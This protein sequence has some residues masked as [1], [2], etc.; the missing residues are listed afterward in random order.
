MR[1]R[2]PVGHPDQQLDDRPPAPRPPRPLAQRPAVHV[3]RDQVLPLL[4][5]PR[6]VHRHDVRVVERG[7]QLRFAL[8]APPRF[9][10]RQRLRQHLDRRRTVELR[11]RRSVHHP[12]PAGAERPVDAVAADQR[13]GL[14]QC[15][16]RRLVPGELGL[17]LPREQRFD[18]LPQ[19]VIVPRLPR[20]ERRPLADRLLQR[21]LV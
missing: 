15:A 4:I 19:S 7:G 12:H 3:L 5:L 17:L 9:R 18:L 10:I 21:R 6:V 16:G 1:R 11:V 20:H 14:E 8:K 2:D 13:A